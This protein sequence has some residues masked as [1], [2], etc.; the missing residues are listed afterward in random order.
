M[1][2]FTDLKEIMALICN[3]G[4]SVADVFLQEPNWSLRGITRDLTQPAS[5]D[6][7]RKGV[8]MF[9]A[10]VDKPESLREAFQGAN[11]IFGVTDFWTPMYNPYHYAKLRPGQTINEFCFDLELKRGK[12]IADAAATVE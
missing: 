1:L 8:H 6:W 5:L 9:Q 12:S 3:K 7:E 10:D 4:A 2:S 11:V